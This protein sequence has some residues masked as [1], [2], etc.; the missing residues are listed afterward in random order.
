MH[1]ILCIIFNALYSMDCILCIALYVLF[2]LHCIIIHC[3]L[4]YALYSTHCILCELL[5][6]ESCCGQ[7]DIV[8]YKPAIAAKNVTKALLNLS[9]AK[10]HFKNGLCPTHFQKKIEQGFRPSPTGRQ[11]M[12]IVTWRATIPAKTLS[13]C[14]V[15]LSGR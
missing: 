15:E 1:C 6:F 8:T 5:N 9:W 13:F 12:D 3:N 14:T 2:S 11:N 4:F 7:T 10:F